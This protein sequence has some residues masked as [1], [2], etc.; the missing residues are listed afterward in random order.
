MIALENITIGHPGL[1]LLR[2]VTARVPGHALVALIGRNGSGKSTLLR[3]I[4]GLGAVSHGNIIISGKN[5]SDISALDMAKLV[6]YVGTG[7]PR[8]ANMTCREVVATGRAPYTDWIG[9]LR[10]DDEEAVDSAFNAVGMTEF[11]ARHFNT[12]SDGEAQRIM[13]ARALAQDTPLILLDEPTSFLDV[14]AR[15]ELCAL[16]KRL[17]ESGRSIMFSTHELEIAMHD[18]DFVALLDNPSLHVM[19][20]AE[21]KGS[22][23]LDKVF[24]DALPSWVLK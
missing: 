20:P 6:S 5:I 2:D 10:K 8:I 21:L 18:A 23:L 17:T 9:R 14:A 11:A 12:L 1:T 16:L 15:Y 4:A 3:A 24:G 22:G 19:R 13:I 7:R